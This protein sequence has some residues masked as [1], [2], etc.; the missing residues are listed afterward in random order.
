M[1]LTLLT[2]SPI[3]VGSGEEINRFGIMD[4]T[5]SK[6][7]NREIVIL[8]DNRLMSKIRQKGLGDKFIQFIENSTRDKTLSD[9]C[10]QDSIFPDELKNDCSAY[11]IELK[12]E[13]KLA[14]HGRRSV[15]NIRLFI[16]TIDVYV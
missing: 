13:V 10:G 4:Y 9:F 11:P 16:K 12:G 8:D 2:L 6:T 5:N 14:K 7:G 15:K 1:E 3:F